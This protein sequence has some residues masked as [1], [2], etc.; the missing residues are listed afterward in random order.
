MIISVDQT[1]PQ[2]DTYASARTR[3]LYNVGAEDGSRFQLKADVPI[4]R[5]DWQIGVVVGPSGSGKSSILR[6]LATE[7]WS[8]YSAEWPDGPIIDALSD[9]GDYSKAT[10]SL[11]SVGLGS[12]PSWLRPRRVLSMG[13]GFRADMAHLLLS[14]R[15]RV[16][17]DEFTSVLDRKVA[18][19]GAKAF[20]KAWRR[21]PDR[22][23]ILFSCHYDC[24]AELAPDWVCDLAGSEALGGG[25][26]SVADTASVSDRDRFLGPVVGSFTAGGGPP[27]T[28]IK[29][30]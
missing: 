16:M 8:E 10:S 7:G 9:A 18:R 29:Q 11:S 21:S 15:D 12:V 14:G 24:L 26:A 19:V 25:S 28:Y 22:K 17:L 2:S 3:S 23:V 20:A 30:S 4:E 13:E 5:D 1:V 27:I 6:A